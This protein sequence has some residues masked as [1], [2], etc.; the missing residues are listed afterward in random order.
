MRCSFYSLLFKFGVKIIIV[1]GNGNGKLFYFDRN[2][3]NALV[4]LSAL[5][6]GLSL[7]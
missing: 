7:L 4:K 5:K 6:E 1:S 2:F 3:K